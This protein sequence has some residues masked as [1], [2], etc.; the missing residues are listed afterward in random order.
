MIR[1]WFVTGLDPAQYG[2]EEAHPDTRLDVSDAT[3]VDVIHTNTE[4]FHPLLGVGMK[5]TVGKI[6]TFYAHKYFIINRQVCPL[7]Y[8]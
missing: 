1:N 2:F 5:Q 3:F 7:L 8:T 4:P 6:S